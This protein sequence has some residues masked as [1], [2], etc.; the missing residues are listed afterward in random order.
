MTPGTLLRTALLVSGAT[1]ALVTFA[2]A[3]GQRGPDQKRGEA[4][5][6]ESCAVCHAVGPTGD[7]PVKEAPAFRTLSER[8]PV[9][10]L[11]EALAEGITVGHE[12]V[13]MPEF[14]F[15]PEDVDDIIA[16]LQSIQA[17]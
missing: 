16:Y 4:L 1:L 14:A 15:S 8:Y 17:R 5:V 6:R 12:G 9:E 7:S 11:Q 10:H 13:Q 2:E 3:R